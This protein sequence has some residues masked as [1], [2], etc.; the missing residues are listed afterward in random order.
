[1]SRVIYPA[2]FHK[3]EEGGYSISFPDFDYV[4]TQGDTINEAYEMSIDALYLAITSTD[5][6]IPK[7][8]AP[9]NIKCKKSESIVLIDFDIE[10]YA[11]RKNLKAVKK[12]LSIPGWLN[13][14]AISAGINFSEVLQNAL[15]KELGLI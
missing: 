2:V 8:T 6:K 5:T 14:S 9:E 1:M 12:T 10:E 3:E 13:E 11:R 7:A 15:K 4:F